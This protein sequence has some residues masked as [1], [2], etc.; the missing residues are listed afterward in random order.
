MFSEVLDDGEVRKLYS[1][2]NPK[3]NLNVELAPDL[4]AYADQAAAVTDGWVFTAAATFDATNDEIDH[5]SG[6]AEVSATYDGIV[7]SGTQYVVTYTVANYTG[8]GNFR[9]RLGSSYARSV[10]ANGTYT[11][12]VTAN[13]T[14]VSFQAVNSTCGGSLK[15]VSVTEASTLVDFS[16]RSASSTKWYNA[17]IPSLYNGTLQGGVTLSAGSTDH[18]VNGA[19]DV[20]GALTTTGN[21]TINDAGELR[22]YR[23]GNSAYGAMYMDLGET[24]YLNNSYQGK[25]LEFSRTGNLKVPGNLGVGTAPTRQLD[26]STAGSCEVRITNSTD[27]KNLLLVSGNASSTAYV[28]TLTSGEDLRIQANGGDT[29]F[30]GALSGTTG[31]FSGHLV[32]DQVKIKHNYSIQYWNKAD[33]TNLGY[34]LMRMMELITSPQR[35]DKILL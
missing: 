34:L 3:K 17:A 27:T 28:S 23:S 26:V 9:V 12:T 8:T 19:I 6:T 1:G 29:T 4:T 2:E 15:S 33:D 21:V 11:D 18:R 35:E 22:T 16:P 32:T 7:S 24:L 5:A 14:N 25:K 31:T 13:G 20:D 30:G 10:A